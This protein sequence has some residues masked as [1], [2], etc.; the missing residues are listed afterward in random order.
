LVGILNIESTTPGFFGQ[1]EM[2][3]LQAFVQVAAVALKNAQ[4][5][6]QAHQ[7]ITERVKALKKSET[8]P[9][10]CSIPPARW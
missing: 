9:Q 4:L 3:R 6:N 5:Y 8:L 1:T 2:E 7:E 10:L